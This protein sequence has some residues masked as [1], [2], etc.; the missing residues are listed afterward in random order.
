M[1]G[2]PLHE[3]TSHEDVGDQNKLLSGRNDPPLMM[4]SLVMDV[5]G[6]CARNLII[7]KIER[8]LIAGDVLRAETGKRVKL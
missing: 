5:C 2:W 8:K 3:A 6:Q 7:A 4:N 1:L